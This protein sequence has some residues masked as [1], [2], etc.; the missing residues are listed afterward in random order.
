MSLLLHQR[1]PDPDTEYAVTEINLW[2]ER[3]AMFGYIRSKFMVY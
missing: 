3:K 2:K 1:E